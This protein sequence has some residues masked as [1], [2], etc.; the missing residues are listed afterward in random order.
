MAFLRRAFLRETGAAL[1]RRHRGL[2]PIFTEMRFESYAEDFLQRMTNPIL[3]DSFE[4]VGRD[5]HRK[6]GWDDRLVGT[7]RIALEQGITPNRFAVGVAAALES[8][9]QEHRAESF[10]RSIWADAKPDPDKEIQVLNLV[11]PA[12][13]RLQEW[14]KAGCPEDCRLLE[15][16][17]D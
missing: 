12:I 1:I 8:I 16:I 14:R 9:N 3:A 13:E 10:L 2:D 6:L 7:M 17:E 5:A 4:R 11:A 15:V